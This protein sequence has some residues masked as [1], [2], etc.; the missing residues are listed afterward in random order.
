[1]DAGTMIVDREAAYSI[2]SQKTDDICT[3]L[4]VVNNI[5]AGS[6]YA[7]FLVPAHDCGDY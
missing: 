3:D 6:T 5:A 2:C 7:G 1:M 4:S